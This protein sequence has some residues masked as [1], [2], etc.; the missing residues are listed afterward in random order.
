MQEFLL[1]FASVWTFWWPF[2][3]TQESYD[4]WWASWACVWRSRDCLVLC[5]QELFTTFYIGFLGLIF[6]AFLMYLV[7]R[8]INSSDFSSYADA[9]WWGVVMSITYSSFGRTCCL[10]SFSLCTIL[11]CL[12]SVTHHIWKISNLLIY[13]KAIFVN[14]FKSWNFLHLCDISKYAHYDHVDWSITPFS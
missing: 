3:F 13:F 4:I 1:S 12:W 2:Y 14:A 9:L 6:S 5:C 11:H 7:E 8:D 10:N